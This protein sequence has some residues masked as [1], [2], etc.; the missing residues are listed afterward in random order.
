MVYMESAYKTTSETINI[1]K[2]YSISNFYNFHTSV[3]YVRHATLNIYRQTPRNFVH[4]R[5]AITN[6]S[7]AGLYAKNQ[8]FTN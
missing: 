5:V 1:Y 3:I 4:I 6:N 2:K 7:V 8:Y